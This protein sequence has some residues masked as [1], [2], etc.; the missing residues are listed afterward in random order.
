MLKNTDISQE[1]AEYL[2]SHPEASDTLEGIT[3]WWLLSQRIYSETKKVQEAVAILIEKGR[4]VAIKGKDSKIRYRLS[5][6]KIHAD[7]T[8]C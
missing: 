6:P 5:R 1:I 8:D 7:D 2:R 3:E 4:L